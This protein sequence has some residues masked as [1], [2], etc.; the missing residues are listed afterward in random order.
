MTP[1]NFQRGETIALALDAVSGDPLSVVAISAAMKAVMPGRTHIHAGAPIAALFSVAPRIAVGD[2][3]PGW[4]LTIPAA[5]CASLSSGTY[6]AD[7]KIEVSGG[8][9]VTETVALRIKESVSA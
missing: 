4:T 7:A 2:V 5:V 9:I 1:Y 6:L 3:P 8:V